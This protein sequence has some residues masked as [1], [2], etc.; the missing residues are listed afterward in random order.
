M[1]SKKISIF[2]AGFIWLMVALRIGGRAMG[3]L[4]PYFQEPSWQLGL[5]VVS[6]IIGFGKAFSVLKKSVAR[7][8]ANTDSLENKPM[9]YAL[10]WLKLYGKKGVIL[11]LLMIGLGFL[12]RFLKT[13]GADPYNLFGFLYMGVALA[14]AIGSG[15]YFKEIKNY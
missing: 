12:L 4:E 7:N 14:L 2:I 8:L 15:F 9:D 10:G 3:W 5:L 11:I 6:V 1:N 13:I